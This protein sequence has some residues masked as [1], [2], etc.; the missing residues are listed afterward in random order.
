M[1]VIYSK[2]VRRVRLWISSFLSKYISLYTVVLNG[3]LYIY[4]NGTKYGV[5]NYNP[6]LKGI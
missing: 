2:A 3:V 5:A 4:D 6:L 1:I